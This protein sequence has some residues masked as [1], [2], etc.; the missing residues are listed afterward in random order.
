MGMEICGMPNLP[1]EPVL[2]VYDLVKQQPSIEG[3]GSKVLMVTTVNW[4][5]DALEVRNCLGNPCDGLQC[6]PNP[7]FEVRVNPYSELDQLQFSEMNLSTDTCFAVQ[8]TYDDSIG[9]DNLC[10]PS[11]LA[12]FDTQDDARY[13]VIDGQ[14]FLPPMI[15]NLNFE[16]LDGPPQ[17]MCM[18]ECCDMLDPPP[19]EWAFQFSGMGIPG[20]VELLEGEVLDPED[21]ITY[22]MRPAT[23]KNV[24]SVVLPS[25]DRPISWV[26]STLPI[27]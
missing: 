11:S 8:I 15:E 21:G 23:L 27:E 1:N 9:Y 13:M 4:E 10:R 6:D 24:R 18:E 22:A 26:L 5:G 7:Y 2:E 14:T 20:F 3:C 12:L 25:C 16:V 17:C 19:G